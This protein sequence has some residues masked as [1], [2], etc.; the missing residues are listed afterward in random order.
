MNWLGKVD[1]NMFTNDSNFCDPTSFPD[2]FSLQKTLLVLDRIQPLEHHLESHIGGLVL[3]RTK[4]GIAIQLRLLFGRWLHKRREG[5][6][7]EELHQRTLGMVQASHT[8]R[9]Q[10][11]A[12]I[13]DAQLLV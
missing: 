8:T 6:S 3:D 4:A 1:E 2:A 12:K 9:N 10:P 11:G 7:I 13:S 5:V